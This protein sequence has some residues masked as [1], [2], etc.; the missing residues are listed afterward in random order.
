[1]V[2]A[3]DWAWIPERAKAVALLSMSDGL[4]PKHC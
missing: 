3:L 1:M 4:I 2:A